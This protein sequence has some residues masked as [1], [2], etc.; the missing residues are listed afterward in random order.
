[1]MRPR[2]WLTLLPVIIFAA[3][4]AIFWRGLSGN[5]SEVPSVLI[6]K[7]VP[8]FNLPAVDGLGVP[9]LATKDLQ[10]GTVTVVNIWASW[11]IPCRDEHPLLMQLSKRSDI[12]LV[13]INNK[14]DADNARRFLG[15]LGQ[16]FAAVGADR[17]GRTSIDWG[18]YGVPETFIV[19]GKG[20]IRYK[21]I[22]GLTAEALAGPLNQQIEIAK[23]P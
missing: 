23:K 18:A 13:G 14:D 11:C 1:M 20:T 6:G 8:N 3:L 15:T 7:P 9:G 5:P 21:L 22:G 17:D 10:Q 19:D 16:P 4:A 12:R 2:L